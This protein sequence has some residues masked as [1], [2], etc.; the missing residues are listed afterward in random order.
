M[1]SPTAIR[2]L[3]GAVPGTGGT[4]ADLGWGDGTFTLALA[5]RLGSGARIIAI[6]QDPA[7]LSRLRRTAN[8]WVPYPISPRRL[9][10]IAASAGLSDLKIAATSPST[11][12]GMLYA[13]YSVRHDSRHTTEMETP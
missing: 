4:W 8:R 7:A 11:F 1:D 3:E 10:E 5:D 13:A 12:S 2:L 6:D 9:A